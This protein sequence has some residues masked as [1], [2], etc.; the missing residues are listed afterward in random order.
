MEVVPGHALEWGSHEG[1]DGLVSACSPPDALPN[2]H[3]SARPGVS[4]PLLPA[5]AWFALT[6]GCSGSPGNTLPPPTRPLEDV[7][8]GSLSDQSTSSADLPQARVPAFPLA[9]SD[10]TGH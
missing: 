7:L 9:R 5:S 6:P 2:G 10:L 1:V 3:H 8:P 4:L